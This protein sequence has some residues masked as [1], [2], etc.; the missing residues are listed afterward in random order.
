MKQEPEDTQT[1]GTLKEGEFHPAANSAMSYIKG[2]PHVDMLMWMET[3][4]S[5]ALSG[6]R[7]AEICSET[8]D[9]VMTNKPVSDRYLLGLAWTLMVLEMEKGKEVKKEEEKL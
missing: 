1:V 4:A 7:L 8:L 3:L 6:S 2:I 5:T 9:R